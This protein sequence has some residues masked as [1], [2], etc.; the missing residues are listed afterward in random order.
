MLQLHSALLSVFTIGQSWGQ[1]NALNDELAAQTR[2][3]KLPGMVAVVFNK[4][5]VRATGAAGV[6]EIGKPAEVAVTDRFHIGSNAKAMLATV[7][8]ILVD[9][10]KLSWDV[11]AA[12]LLQIRNEDPRYA[13]VTL[14]DLLN[15]HAGLPAFEDDKAPEWKA[16]IANGATPGRQPLERFSQWI[17]ARPPAAPPGTKFLYSNAGYSVAAAIAEKVTG[18]EWKVLLARRLFAPLN[19]DADFGNPAANRSDQPQGHYETKRGLKVQ[20]PNESIPAFIQPAGDVQVSIVEYVKFLQL[21]LRGLA[22]VDGTLLKSSTIRRMHT[23]TDKMGFGWKISDIRGD[24]ASFHTGSADTFY[25][26]ATLVPARDIGV[27]VFANAGG[28]RAEA[29]CVAE[30]KALLTRFIDPPAD[31]SKRK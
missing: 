28:G 25:A 30:T 24:A 26:I 22:A 11:P 1:P 6:R 19:M 29:A 17:L 9:E 27:A 13:R 21:H 12:E 7:A 15:H 2:A 10:G 3:H 4:D 20:D 31:A 8:G 23:P 16:W 14:T 5:S 18:V